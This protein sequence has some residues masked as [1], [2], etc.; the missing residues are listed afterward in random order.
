[1]HGAVLQ[2]PLQVLQAVRRHVANVCAEHLQVGGAEA[3]AG[4]AGD[5]QRRR[6]LHA[7]RAGL[8]LRQ[9][10]ARRV[11]LLPLLRQLQAQA[12]QLVL[13]ALAEQVLGGQAGDGAQRLEALLLHAGD[14]VAVALQLL[15]QR[16]ALLRVRGLRLQ[17]LHLLGAQLGLQLVHLH[18]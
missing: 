3:E 4:H 14:V 10:G 1:M 17:A 8:L 15:L 13:L 2:H 9:E 6:L 18:R 16:S 11:Q 12:G 5:G 7:G